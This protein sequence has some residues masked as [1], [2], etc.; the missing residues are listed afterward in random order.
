M[1]T[2]SRTENTIKNMSI[3]L[4]LYGVSYIAVF[5]S[6]TFFVKILGNDYLSI[7]GLFT[8][9]ITLVSFTELGLSTASI[10]CLYKPIAEKNY[11]KIKALID[12]FGKLYRVVAV[13]SVIVG[14]A[15]IPILPFLVDMEDVSFTTGYLSTVYALFVFNTTASYIFVQKRLFLVADQKNYI[16]NLISQIIHIT[17]LALQTVFLIYTHNYIGYLI[18]QIIC[19]LIT[20]IAITKYVNI[21]YKE[22]FSK[23]GE[24]KEQVTDEEKKLLIKNLGAIFFYK[25]GAVILNGTDNIILS[26]VIKTSFVGL[27]SNYTLVINAIN[28]VIMQCFNGIGASIGNHTVNA[29]KIDQ[30]KTFRQLDLICVIAFSFCSICLA[31]LLNPLIEVWL[32]TDYLLPIGT[33]ISLVLVFYITG[34]NQIPS[35]YRTSLGLFKDAKIYPLMA[36]LANIVLSVALAKIIGLVGVFAAT[37]IVRFLFFT[38]LDSRLTYKKGFD[39]SPNKYYFK[40][41]IRLIIVALGYFI[42]LLSIKWIS[43]T[44]IYGLIVKTMVV[45]FVTLIYLLVVYGWTSDF[46]ALFTKIKHFISSKRLKDGKI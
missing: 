22:L 7:S 2:S 43:F 12:F 38:L 25:I 44:G 39:M 24:N 20:N 29:N 45:C 13:A 14:G 16:V 1:N 15:L 26:V 34:V 11:A 27:C 28:S 19:T 9:V 41:A 5:I 35:L 10:Y 46:R 8:N 17:Q 23:S 18:I 3:N 30:E 32:G 31:T 36:A 4:L 42:S 21:K 37:S 6:R 40:F 33:V